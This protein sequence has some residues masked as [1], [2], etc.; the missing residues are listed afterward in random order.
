MTTLK[1]S[2]YE[3]GWRLRLTFGDGSA[4]EGRV[5]D[6]SRVAGSW[7]S[8]SLY[9]QWECGCTLPL[10]ERITDITVLDRPSPFPM[11]ARVVVP[12]GDV[13]IVTGWAPLISDQNRWVVWARPEDWGESGVSYWSDPSDLTLAPEPEPPTVEV[14]TWWRNRVTGS[15]LVAL[16]VEGDIVKMRP[17]RC[18]GPDVVAQIGL[19]RVRSRYDRL[20]GPPEP[21]P[22]DVYVIADQVWHVSPNGRHMPTGSPFGAT[23]VCRRYTPAQLATLRILG[24]VGGGG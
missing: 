20:D 3:A 11:G 4:A 18:N 6:N 16:S 21:Q 12:T 15:V 9:L 22:G 24:N 17:L 10:S 5:T 8:V 13:K 1:S 23:P 2:D 7:G 19:S 14:G